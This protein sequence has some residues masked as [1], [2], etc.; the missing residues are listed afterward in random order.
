[1]GPQFI[2]PFNYAY[3][4]MLILCIA[5]SIRA[6]RVRTRAFLILLGGLLCWLI[7]LGAFWYEDMQWVNWFEGIP[8]P[9]QA[10]IASYDADPT[11][12]KSFVFLF[13]LP[14]SALLIFLGWAVA[15]C[16]LWFGKWLHFRL[17]RTINKS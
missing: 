2:N 6:K 14:I 17:L 3:V 16:V 7:S 9:S 11:A 12:T 4:A 5:L 8:N 10:K 1:M 15:N 13:G